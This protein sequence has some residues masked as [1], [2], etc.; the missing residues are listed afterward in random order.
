MSNNGSAFTWAQNGTT[1]LALS[2]SNLQPGVDNTTALGSGSLRWTTVY[3]VTGTI[4]TSDR[5]DKQQIADLTVAEKAVGQALK[6]MMKTFK[7]N[8]AV[9]KKGADARIHFGV[10]AQDVQAAFQ[11]QGLDADNYGVFCSDTLPDGS[12][13]LGVRY[14]EL[15]ALIIGAL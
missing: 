7:F 9:Q 2:S 11:A 15:F 6:G 8:D 13:R 14:E 4:N 12:T 10:I 5:N 1:T 3:A